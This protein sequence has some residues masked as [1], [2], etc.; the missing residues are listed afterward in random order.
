MFASSLKCV[1]CDS[2]YPLGPMFLGCQRCRGDGALEVIYD[3]PALGASNEYSWQRDA[4]NDMWAYADLLPVKEPS[5]PVSLGEGSTPMLKLDPDSRNPLTNL[6]VKN[7][8]INPTGAFKDRFHAVS[9]SVA[10]ELGYSGVVASTTGNHGVSLASY[11]RAAGLKAVIFADPQCPVTQRDAMRALGATVMVKSKRRESLAEFVS[12]YGWYPS[13]YMTPMP[14]STPYG[15]EGYKTM[16]FEAVR[17]LG[18]APEHFFFPTAAGDGFYGP[19]KGFCEF[20]ALGESSRIPAMHAV[21]ANGADWLV[22]TLVTGASEP[23]SSEN[24]ATV[25]IS[26]GDATGGFMCVKAIKESGGSA[27]AVSDD[28]ILAAE[29]YLADHGLLVEPA[30]AAAVAGAWAKTRDGVIEKDAV[31]VCVLTGSAFKWPDAVRSMADAGPDELVEPPP[32]LV[33]AVGKKLD[34]S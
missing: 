33:S 11:A 1:S 25:A 14:V 3:L 19:W 30:S 9:V 5:R 13:T 6:Y 18:D 12:D 10:K 15:V 34:Q 28:D 29:R 23:I 26:I 22:Q 17:D 27:V 32:S 4:R 24:P 21:Q 8:T 7:E 2:T 16:A 31:C 20:T